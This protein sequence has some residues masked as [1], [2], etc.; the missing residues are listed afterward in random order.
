MYDVAAVNTNADDD[1]DDNRVQVPS[2]NDPRVQ[3]TLDL[4]TRSLYSEPT[5][6]FGVF[7]FLLVASAFGR[8]CAEAS[9]RTLEN[10][11][12]TRGNDTSSREA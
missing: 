10:S 8:R 1:H 5:R 7:F 3:I 4:A 6:N 9:H 2:E 12:G 11:S